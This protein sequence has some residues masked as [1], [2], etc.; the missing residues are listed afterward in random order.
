MG[1]GIAYWLATKRRT[2]LLT[3]VNAGALGKAER[4]LHELCAEA[5]KRQLLTTTEAQAVLDRIVLTAGE[6][7]LS[8]ADLVIE[9][10][11]EDASIKQTLWINLLH[12]ARPDALLATNTSA[13]PLAGLLAGHRLLGLHFFNPVSSMPLVE[14]VRGAGNSDNDLATAIHFV[15]DLGKLPVVVQDRP[16]FL[17][18][19]VLMP[20]LLEAAQLVQ[21]G[22]AIKSVD[23][24]MLRFGMPMGPLRLLDEVG[25]DVAMH[26]VHTLADAFPDTLHS[27]KW[28][29]RRVHAGL[30]G[31][32]SGRGYYNFLRDPEP[33][34][35][36]D[37]AEKDVAEVMGRLPLLLTNEAARCLDEGVAESAAVIDLGMVLGTGYAPFRGG[38][39]RYADALGLSA[40]VA[41]LSHFAQQYGPLY[42]PAAGLRARAAGQLSYF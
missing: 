38:P 40:V 34:D 37:L 26:V 21:D 5:I 1:C 20:Y 24:A 33:E 32:K 15:Q 18:N 28:L 13:L 9:A 25:L 30:L 42:Q 2:V 22:Y 39:L 10:A 35:G 29:E 8:R 3:D 36:R 14:I 16:G 4:R 11:V 31:K 17:V 7:S 6:P 19:R 12:R 41:Q 27:P 23:E